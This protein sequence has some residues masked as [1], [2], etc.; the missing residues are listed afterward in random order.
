MTNEEMTLAGERI[1]DFLKSHGSNQ[2]DAARD[3][4]RLADISFEAA[5]T[6]ISRII[7]GKFEADMDFLIYLYK[8]HEANIGFLLT[9]L[10]EKHVKSFKPFPL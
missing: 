9:G 4:S 7:N 5:Q 3:F 6:K 2:A 10:G 1:R 8:K